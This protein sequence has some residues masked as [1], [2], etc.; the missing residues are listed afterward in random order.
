M[1]MYPPFTPFTRLVVTTL[2]VSAE[3]RP[4]ASP[5]VIDGLARGRNGIEI[6]NTSSAPVYLGADDVSAEN[7]LPLAAGESR[8]FPVTRSSAKSLYIASEDDAA[9]TLAEYF[10]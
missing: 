7:G 8:Y 10:A 2:D 1:S 3:P 4:L 5:A 9:V 6:V